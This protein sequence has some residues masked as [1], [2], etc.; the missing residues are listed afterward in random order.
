MTAPRA[1]DYG[2]ALEQVLP[3]LRA[4]GAVVDAAQDYRLG[5]GSEAELDRKLAEYHAVLAALT[6]PPEE[7]PP[8][9]GAAYPGLTGLRYRG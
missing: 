8:G 4:M 7:T 6:G 5:T 9:R 3:F 2:T 1:D